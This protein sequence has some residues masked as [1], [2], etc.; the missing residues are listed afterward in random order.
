MRFRVKRNKP[1]GSSEK[2]SS[3]GQ[4]NELRGAKGK[5]NLKRIVIYLLVSQRIFYHLC[6]TGISLIIQRNSPP[7][8]PQWRADEDSI[9]IHVLV[10][11]EAALHHFFLRKPRP[12]YS[13]VVSMDRQHGGPPGS[14][15]EM[16]SKK[17][18]KEVRCFWIA[19][20]WT[21]FPH[22]KAGML[23][24]PSLAL[25]SKIL[26]DGTVV[27]IFCL[28]SGSFSHSFES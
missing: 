3:K 12:L 13:K 5:T 26:S 20:V 11:P 7:E 1:A 10:S 23:L 8:A 16:Q 19:K 9:Q 21:A 4:D 14:W 22:L 28:L 27:L 25:K 15:L 6:K 17:K 24:L 18:G 2:S